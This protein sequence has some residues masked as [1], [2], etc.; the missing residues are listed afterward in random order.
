MKKVFF[1]LAMFLILG[2]SL[3]LA[4]ED[5]AKADEDEVL[6]YKELKD[7]QNERRAIGLEVTRKRTEASLERE[8]QKEQED[9]F[10][11]AKKARRAKA[12]RLRGEEQYRQADK[13]PK[14]LEQE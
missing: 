4:Q 6:V 12:R 11:E 2:S 3:G 5:K 1:L 10:S 14:A 9:A 13:Q 8:G 7:P